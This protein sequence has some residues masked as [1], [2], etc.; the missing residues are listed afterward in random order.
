[1]RNTLLR[2]VLLF[3][4]GWLMT[5]LLSAT[6][7][8]ASEQKVGVVLLHGKLASPS[9]NIASLARKL[10]SEG[11]LVERPDMAWSG[12]RK[13]DRT[14][15]DSVNEISDTI[16]K[17]RSRGA[18]T[19]ITGG[20]SLGANA[21]IRYAA[22]HNDIN[23]VLAI[24]P[25]HV[26]EVKG[27]KKKIAKSVAKARK[28]VSAGKGDKRGSF[29]DVNQGK[30][31]SINVPAEIYL[32]YFDPNGPAVM[33]NNIR[34]ISAPILWVIGKGD[35]MNKK[36]KKYAFNK[37]PSNPLNRYLVVS[38]GHKDTPDRARNEITAWIKELTAK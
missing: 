25:G 12:S 16:T 20:H 32:S 18:D 30:K 24:A 31:Y 27:Y 3:F 6:A 17:L 23:G 11:F 29:I 14:Y 26:P 35:R 15:D 19:I 1:M 9:K 33:P 22:T 2:G 13:Y 28:M 4:S 34:S 37:A 38:G 10:E 21:A 36:G 5:G 8:M 7:V